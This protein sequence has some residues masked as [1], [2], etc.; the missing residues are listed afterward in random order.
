MGRFVDGNG[1]YYEGDRRDASDASVQTR[2]IAQ[3]RAIQWTLIKAERDRRAEAGVQV[4]AHW[5]HT[6]NTSRIKQLGL[7]DM[8]RDAMANGETGSTVLQKLG[9]DIGW[10]TMAGAFV[11]MTVQLAIDIVAKVGDLDAL[12]FY[13][14]EQHRIAME[15]SA[16][17]LAYDFSTG[18]PALFGG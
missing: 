2:P 5:F 7:K 10:K 12:I 3:A 17:P 9:T 11:P 13:V 18:W 14:A 15:A 6:D 16:D 8:A 1:N 4:G